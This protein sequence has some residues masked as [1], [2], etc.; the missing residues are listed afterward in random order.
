[1]AVQI[2]K[3]RGPN[4]AT[5]FDTVWKSFVKLTQSE[6]CTSSEE[7][8]VSVVGDNIGKK[9]RVSQGRNNCS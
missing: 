2:G 9:P 3:E 4:L 8:Q 1:M 7:I 5:V 6:L